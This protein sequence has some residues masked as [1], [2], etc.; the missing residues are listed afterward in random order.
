MLGYFIIFIMDIV[1]ATRNRG[2]IEEIR[3]IL[4]G[5]PVR[6]YGTE[7]FPGCPEVEESEETFEGNAVKKAWAVASFTGK[8]A[9]ADDS[10]LEVYALGGGPGVLS[11][12]YA[13][14][15]AS[16]RDNLVKLLAEMAHVEDEKRGARFVCAMALALP[17]GAVETFRGTVDGRIGRA[18]V[19]QGGFGYDPVFYPEGHDRTFSQMSPAEKDALSH[20][21]RALKE[22]RRRLEE[23]KIK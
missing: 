21:G 18:P 14:R 16:D 13:G 7:D 5:L 12:R 8:A 19:G 10:G 20:R 9:L 6:L 15:G 4:A 1:V 2:K 17:D 3:R 22:L 23:G 11:A